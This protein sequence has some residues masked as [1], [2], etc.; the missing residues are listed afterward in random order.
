MANIRS[1]VNTNSI[2]YATVVRF[3]NMT[4]ILSHTARVPMY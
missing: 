3:L 4:Q 1:E 2:G